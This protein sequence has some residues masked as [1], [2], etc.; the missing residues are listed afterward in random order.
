MNGN[1]SFEFKKLLKIKYIQSNVN[2]YK[3]RTKRV[4][5]ALFQVS[6]F[7]EIR[8]NVFLVVNMYLIM[9]VL[10]PFYLLQLFFQSA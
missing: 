4:S 2:L 9:H 6:E 8:M 10:A 5:E 3:L 7:Q 1:Y